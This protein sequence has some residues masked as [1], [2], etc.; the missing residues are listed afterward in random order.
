MN[1]QVNHLWRRWAGLVLG[2][3]LAVGLG[4]GSSGGRSPQFAS[5][6]L[7]AQAAPMTE[8]RGVWLTNID[9]DVLF[10]TQKLKQ[11][12]ERLARLNFNTIYHRVEL[13]LLSL[14]QHDR[15]SSH[16]SG[17]RPRTGAARTRHDG[18]GC[19]RRPSLRDG[20]DPLV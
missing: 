18:R 14:P 10:S 17:P 20:G 16:W 4:I 8:L 3:L 19:A 11:G 5:K 6:T 9:S 7:A 15:P 2:V 13:G 12:L 1:H